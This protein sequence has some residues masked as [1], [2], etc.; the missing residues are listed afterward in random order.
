VL[1]GEG[2]A[3]IHLHPSGQD[4]AA[5]LDRIAAAGTLAAFT[6][7]FY[8]L[9]QVADELLVADLRMGLTPH[10]VFRF[11]VARWSAEGFQPIAPRRV[12]SAR[13][14]EG[15]FAWLTANLGGTASP[16]PAEVNPTV[17]PS[18]AQADALLPA[19]PPRSC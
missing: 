11:A 7:G 6:K 2:A 13:R 18:M 16:R 10:Y 8:R 19:T 4:L 5:C 3:Q 1:G 14:V 12:P 15:D 9:E 17:A